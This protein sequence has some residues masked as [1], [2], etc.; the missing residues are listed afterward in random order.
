MFQGL[1]TVT[2]ANLVDP[3]GVSFT[4]TSPFWISDN[5]TNMATV[6][7]GVPVVSATTAPMV[8][9]GPTGQVANGTARGVL[10]APQPTRL[11]PISSST[12]RPG[13]ILAWNGGVGGTGTAVQEYSNPS[14]SYTGLALATSGT[15]TYLY[16]ANGNG[17]G[18]ID[19]FNSSW[20]PTTLTGNFKD[21]NL[22]AG[23]VPYN[24]QLIGG[25]LYVT[26][27][28]YNSSGDEIPSGVVD[29][30]NTNGTFVSRFSTS[31]VLD[32]PW[33]ITE[34]PSTFGSFG[35][36]ILI[37]NFLNGEI[38]AFD[39]VKSVPSSAPSTATACPLRTRASGHSNSAPDA[40]VTAPMPSK[41]PPA[42]TTKPMAS[43]E[44]S[45]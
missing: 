12:R 19:V 14:A 23:Y 4:A 1:A 18:S 7:T 9:G 29:I 31:P 34:A 45:R 44:K 13:T 22:P 6:T 41:S 17:S 20:A 36:D 25:Q 15:N 11:P 28:E 39:P 10:V 43:T 5:V 38:N 32:A 27:V 26:Y 33:G 35:G 30:Y 42:S 8:P 21:P 37:G 24:I 40:P 16:A 2:N 3:W